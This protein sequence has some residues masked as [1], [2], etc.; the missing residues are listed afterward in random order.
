MSDDLQN[1][2]QKLIDSGIGDKNRLEHILFTLKNGKTFYNSDRKYAEKLM[3]KIDSERTPQKSVHRE[4]TNSTK[5]D[6]RTP[7]QLNK[8]PKFDTK[9]KPTKPKRVDSTPYGVTYHVSSGS[10]VKIHHNSCRFYSNASQAGS[11]KWVFKTGYQNARKEAQSIA[12]RQSNYWKHAQCCLNGIINRSVS[13]AILITFIPFLG[14]VANLI[15]RDFYPTLGR[16]L[17]YFGLV[18]GFLA[19][20]YYL[21]NTVNYLI[22]DL[23]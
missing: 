23:I 12:Y 13:F 20:I 3:A 16:A 19:I 10:G 11:T 1:K 21:V 18:Y 9:S 17:K 6:S 22:I 7:I 15:V 4:K 14:L 8:K 2:I 5:S